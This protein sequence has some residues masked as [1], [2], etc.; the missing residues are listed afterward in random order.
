M[1]ATW[2]ALEPPVHRCPIPE[3]LVKAMVFLA[4]SWQT[5]RWGATTLLY[6]AGL[7][8][9][10]EV[11]RCRRRDMLLPEDLLDDVPST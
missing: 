9:F 11:L 3:P 8:W 7:L 6:F 5:E 4:M 10:G 1:V 2:E